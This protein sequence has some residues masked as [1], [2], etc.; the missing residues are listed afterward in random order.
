[1]DTNEQLIAAGVAEFAR[2]AA[3]RADTTPVLGPAICHD[4]HLPGLYWFR[5]RGVWLER[6]YYGEVM[7]I[8]Q[9]RF[10]RH[11]CTA[12]DIPD[13]LRVASFLER[14]RHGES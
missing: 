3:I 2:L 12:R 8:R 7:G 9:Y 14:V 4:C 13:A 10:R 6:E 1:M 11:K 5:V